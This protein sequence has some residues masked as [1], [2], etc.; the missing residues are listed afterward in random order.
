MGFECM[1]VLNELSNAADV[2]GPFGLFCFRER[3]RVACD[4]E[5]RNHF[6]LQALYRSILE[7]LVFD[8][9]KHLKI[10]LTMLSPR[11]LV[12]YFESQDNGFIHQVLIF[13]WNFS[14]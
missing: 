7:F 13:V 3:E 2:F 10:E 11:Q 5:Q 12:F 9:S 8:S 4:D 14:M 6:F 1:N